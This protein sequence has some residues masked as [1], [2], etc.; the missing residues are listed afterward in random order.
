M[1]YSNI[2]NVQILIHK[3]QNRPIGNNKSETAQTQNA[4]DNVNKLHYEKCL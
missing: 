3:N 4:I 1:N 2:K